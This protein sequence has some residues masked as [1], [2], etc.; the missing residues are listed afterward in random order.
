M[1]VSSIMEMGKAFLTIE[2]VHKLER[3]NCRSGHITADH[4]CNKYIYP[5]SA[6]E[7][8]LDA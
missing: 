4:T 2:T 3:K 7:P 1:R 8:A 6:L 5:A